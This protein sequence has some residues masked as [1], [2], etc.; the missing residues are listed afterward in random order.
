VIFDF[1][2]NL[3]PTD[4]NIRPPR[5]TIGSSTSLS[6]RMQTQVAPRPPFGL[7]LTFDKLFGDDVLSWR[8]MEGLFE[9]R[10]NT[11]RIP[12]Y[13]VWF[14]ANDAAI[15]A[16]VVGF[17]D[18]TF[19]ADGTGFLTDDL[20]GVT[21][22]AVQG[23]RTITADFGDYGQLLQAGLFIGLGEYPNLARR[24]WWDGS[25]ARIECAR[26]MMFDL[27]D[28]P[29]KLRPTMLASLT[30]DDGANL[31]LTRARYGSPTLELLERIDGAL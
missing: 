7:K 14:R 24:V 8:A 13:D 6:G 31:E 3:E 18:G 29:L 1:P 10:A 11:V 27:V 5:A 12:L 21:V 9:G 22:T 28:E 26:T 19:F 4:V 25:V 30:S 20:S 16:G 2:A 17:S 23:Q 15:G